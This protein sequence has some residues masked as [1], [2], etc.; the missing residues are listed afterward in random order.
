[1]IVVVVVVIVECGTEL[2]V[3]T[4]PFDVCVM[5]KLKCSN[6]SKP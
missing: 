4:Q 6:P 3:L 5:I 1:L 2:N